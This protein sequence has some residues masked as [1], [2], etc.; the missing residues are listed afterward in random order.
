MISRNLNASKSSRNATGMDSKLIFY[1]YGLQLLIYLVMKYCFAW[2]KW[3]LTLLYWFIT[4]ITDNAMNKVFG[5][6]ISILQNTDDKPLVWTDYYL[7][8]DITKYMSK[9]IK[10]AFSV[11]HDIMSPWVYGMM[12]FCGKMCARK[13][14]GSISK[15]KS[16]FRS[17]VLGN[18]KTNKMLPWKCDS[19]NLTHRFIDK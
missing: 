2:W 9:S 7:S 15:T 17:C 13:S 16:H 18:W 4:Q 19:V 1:L 8:T 6:H 5:H 12:N 3:S 11:G 14:F 10:N